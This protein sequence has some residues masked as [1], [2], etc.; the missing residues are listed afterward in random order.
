MRENK[1]EDR[2]TSKLGSRQLRDISTLIP[3]TRHT[4]VMAT[5]AK[6]RLF[7]ILLRCQASALSVKRSMESSSRAVVAATLWSDGL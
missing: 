1:G 2:V 6:N 5:D 3:I 7:L 4:V